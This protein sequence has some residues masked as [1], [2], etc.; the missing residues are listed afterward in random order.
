M[1]QTFYN[2]LKVFVLLI[3]SITCKAQKYEWVNFYDGVNPASMTVDAAG[4]QYSAFSVSKSF[5][6]DSFKI[7]Y[8][9]PWTFNGLIIKQNTKGKILWHK[10][11]EPVK[12]TTARIYPLSSLMNSNGNLMVFV[13][14][15]THLKI[16]SDTIKRKGSG[17]NALY[18]IEFNDTGKMVRGTNLIEGPQINI[19]DTRTNGVISDD[20]DNLYVSFVSNGQVQ[21]YDSTGTTNLGSSTSDYRHIFL[22]FSN[23]G[24][25]LKWSN[26]LPSKDFFMNS[27]RVDIH[28]N[29]YAAVAWYGTTGSLSFNGKTETNNQKS[30]GTIFIWDKNGNENNCFFIE[31][32]GKQS[33]FHEIAV[34][35]SNS[36]FVSGCYLGDSAKFGSK[37]KRNTKYGVYQYFARYNSKGEVNWVKVEDTTYF[38]V[39]NAN[40]ISSSMTNFNNSF[41]YVSM[42]LPNH[43][44]RLVSF[45]GQKYYPIPSGSRGHGLN[46]KIDERGNILW[47]FRTFVTF[48]SLAIDDHNNFY[49]QGVL[50]M[51]SIIFGNFK[52]RTKDGIDAFI[53]KT[54]DYAIYR[55]NVYTGPYCAGDSLSVPY[56]I[57][58]EFAD[59]NTF[60]AEIS[61]EFG[62]FIGKERIIGKL[63][64][65]NAGTIRGILPMFK[66]ASSGSYRIRIRSTSPQAQSFYKEEKL[67]LLIY[68]RDKADP[69][70][71]EYICYGDSMQ[72]RTYGGTKWT[73]SPKYNMTDSNLRQPWVWP[74]KDTTYKI[75]IADS[76][77]CGAPDT[78]YKKIILRKPLKLTLGF[79]DTIVCD[80]NSFLKIPVHFD[81]GDSSNYYW[82]MYSIVS[83]NVW[84]KVNSGKLNDTL[85]FIPKV[86]IKSSLKIAIVLD[87]ECTNK[88][89]TAYVTIQLLNPSELT[90]KFKDTLLCIGNTISWKAKPTY[91]LSKNSVWEWKDVTNNKVLSTN[92]SLSLTASIT[93]KIR[94]TLSN[95]CTIDSN[96]FIVNVNP[97]LK[98]TILSGRRNLNDTTL[99]LNQSLKLYTKENGGAGKGYNYTWKANGNVVSTT[100]SFVFKP[101]LPSNFTLTL[102]LKDNCTLKA[103]SITKIITVLESPI[104]DFSFD[105]SCT[106][107]ATKF[108][109]KGSVPKPPISTTFL[110]NFNGEDSSTLENPSK[111]YNTTGTKLT[112]LTVL[113]SNGC[114]EEIVKD[115]DVKQQS[116][117]EFTSSYFC[118]ID[119]AVF[120]NT[121][122]DATSYKWDFGDGTNSQI[123]NIKH[124][125]QSGTNPKTYNVKLV[126][127][128]KDGCSDSITQTITILESPKADFTWDIA[129]S[130]AITKFQ[131]TGTNPAN[132]IATSFKWNFNN[133]ATSTIENPSH[134]FASAG[135]S[136]STLILTSS[137]GCS[138]TLIKTIEIKP[139]SKADFTA[140][141]VCENDSVVFVNKS[142]DATGYNWKFGDGQNSK[143]QNPKH[144]YQISSSTTFNVTLVALSECSDSIVQA[145]TVNQNPDANF[146]YTQTGNKLEL[147][148]KAGYFNYRWKM[149][150][151]D[152][153]STANANYTYTLKNWNPLSICLK[154]TDLNG[155]FT[156]SCKTIP[157]GISNLSKLSGFKLYPN[158]NTG[159]FTIEIENPGNDVSIEMYNL[160]G[161]L[162]G[163]LDRVGKVT[164]VDLNVESGIYLVKVR[165][166]GVVWNQKVSIFNSN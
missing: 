11:I 76:S 160:I 164:L 86:T 67:K 18:L 142:K 102:I 84:Q 120:I 145:I 31:G 96:V 123:Q 82:Q 14:C 92:D 101:L 133:E 104:A 140:N 54:F 166:G 128:V 24:Q 64:T 121:S 124:K 51:D 138:D 143:I 49:F 136:S 3:A 156:E 42:E 8:K 17:Y 53:G 72:L 129:C 40:R 65:K 19:Y 131:F 158:P 77:G 10:T 52:G 94:L 99:C 68:S 32:S 15:T 130:K 157:L 113:S 47:G 103:D 125:Y 98:A 74:T 148:A 141:D 119:S 58:G 33:T 122:Q 95:G 87:D 100:D 78:A 2:F 159:N 21:V 57:T 111:L 25:H 13:K 137:N 135:T 152:S 83:P 118:E 154:T 60:F 75:I 79:N 46:M 61:D 80:T 62:N 107:T 132:P 117:A 27:V 48:N 20:Y 59:T 155:C 149:D 108:Q 116:K 147:K 134:K 28:Q 70:P 6:M 151:K 115:I 112:I 88:K 144:K 9:R 50:V 114:K 55:G 85:F 139:Q 66:V 30:K 16:G 97:P 105:K 22:K 89:D 93:T 71:T 35:D 12:D 126:A 23:Y 37:W 90:T 163:R 44:S 146:T 161:E 109:F 73:W 36:I 127:L 34:H 7:S 41:F 63:K 29:L 4:N 162:V 150:G 43:N 38:T 56:T 91:S 165:N 26:T 39:M 45:D 1:N 69:G 153:I 106:K 81:G 5:S 110:W